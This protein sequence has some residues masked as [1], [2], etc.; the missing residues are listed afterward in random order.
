M[1][2]QRVEGGI[3]AFEIAGL[4][5]VAASHLGIVHVFKC[6]P[7]RSASKP[8]WLVSSW[9]A[10][11]PEERLDIRLAFIGLAALAKG[12]ALLVTL[13]K[14][15]FLI[16]RCVEIT[17][18]TDI[19]GTFSIKLCM[20]RHGCADWT[21]RLVNWRKLPECMQGCPSGARRISVR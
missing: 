13:H 4:H 1:Q 11:K 20:S 21:L 8:L 7:H 3:A 16:L 10:S 12:P 9:I 19:E 18:S 5:F 14:R 2:Q 17:P 15:E 6:S